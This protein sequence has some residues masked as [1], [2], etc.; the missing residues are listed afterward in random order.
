MSNVAIITGAGSGFGLG[1]SQK[2][3]SNGWVVYAGDKNPETLKQFKGSTIKPLPLD[4]TDAKAVQAAVDKVIKAEGSMDLM[5][6]NAGYG[7]FS[8]VEETTPEQVRA[9]FEVNFFGVENCVRA[10]LPQMRKQRSGRIL[11]TTSVVAHVSLVGLAEN[12]VATA[13]NMVG[14]EDAGQKTLAFGKFS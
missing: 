8:S 7:N 1:L 4:V 5:V 2:L 12:P 3:A 14:L 10:V 13:S 9:I 11:M 6:A